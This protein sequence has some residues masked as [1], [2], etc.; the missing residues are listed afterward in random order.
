MASFAS[1]RQIRVV[2]AAICAIVVVNGLLR[3]YRQVKA[4]NTF[5]KIADAAKVGTI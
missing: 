5:R 4:T 1:S 3:L 2:A